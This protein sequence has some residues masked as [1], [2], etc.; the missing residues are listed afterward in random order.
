MEYFILADTYE[1]LERTSGKLEKVNILAELFSKIS[2]KELPKVALL[3][4]GI[5]FPKFTSFELGIATQ[6]MIKA[7]AKATGFKPK[8]IEEKFKETGDLGLVTENYIKKRRQVVLFRKKLNVDMIFSNLQKLAFVTGL[9]SQERKLSLI[10]ELLVSAEPKEARYI[11]RTVLGE[12]RIGVAEGI[13]RDAIV[14]AF[15]FKKGMSKEEK[16]KLTGLVE[17]AWNILP[18]F[19]E[20][21]KISKEKGTTGLKKVKVQ[22]GKPI[23][24]MLAEKAESIEDVIEEFGKCAI[25]IKYDGMRVEIEK[26]GDKIF[27]FTRRLENV[28]KQ[29]PDLVDLCKKNLRAKECIVEGEVW[30]VDPKTHFPLPFQQL[31]QRIHRKYDIEKVAKEIPIQ[32]NFFDVV[33]LN[34]KMLFDKKFKERRKILEKIVREVPEKFKLADQL[35]TDNIEKAKKFYNN[36]LELKQE[37]V[38]IKVLDSGYI[39]GRH[40]GGWYKVKPIMET[41]DLVIVGAEW[42][43]GKRANWLS[44]YTL[45]CRDPDTGKFLPCGMMGTGLTEEQ[46]GQMTNTLKQLIITEKGRKVK[47]KPKIVVEIGYQEIQKSPHYESGMALRFPR[48]IRVREDKSPEESDTIERVKELFIS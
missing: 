35:V 45:A 40:V 20:I 42:G 26:Q 25:E 18:D 2:I 19:G 31:S 11:V 44:S 7:I 36:A 4:Q 48:L 21:V 43:T 27:I 33:Y 14:N 39:F 6:M 16:N 10:T 23:R 41:L 32:V 8:E 3:T 38:I 5:V 34:G 28:T 17:H 29:F 15:L 37:G 22:L 1:K 13:I 24:L 47:L 12:L 9:G 46:F 30:G